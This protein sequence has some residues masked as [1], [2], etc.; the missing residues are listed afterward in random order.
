MLPSTQFIP[1][2]N[3]AVLC[4]G[5]P[6]TG[7]TRL[8]MAFPDPG[9]LD[10]DG[11]L[12]SAIEVSQGKKFW[13]A[14]GFAKDDGT[15]IPEDQRWTK[16]CNDLVE[17]IKHPEVKTIWVDGLSNLCRWGLVHAEKQ[18]IAGGINVKKEYLAKYQAFIPLLS[19]FITTLRIPKKFV[20]V[21]VHQTLEKG[22]LDGRVYYK[23]DIP[24]RLADTLAGQFTDAWGVE[25]SPDPGSV[26]GAKY[27][28][29]TKPTGY[30]VALK[31][32]VDLPPVFDVTGLSP[33]DVWTK[34][35]AARLMP[36]TPVPPTTLPAPNLGAV[37]TQQPQS[38]KLV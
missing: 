12:R 34:H 10:C 32:S 38:V 6:G 18:L 21:T 8:G 20:F 3:V 35:L 9:I 11:N 36:K 22:E 14:Q 5:F 37:S 27:K 16:V 31:T 30:H 17:M 13:V 24:G 4:V 19:N 26:V 28:V 25:A 1:S 15:E 33:N 7:H 23:L 2:Q 29:N